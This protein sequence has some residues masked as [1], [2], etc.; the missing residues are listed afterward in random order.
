LFAIALDV[1]DPM[2]LDTQRLS[3]E[4]LNEHGLLLQAKKLRW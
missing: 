4:T 3:Y 2:I 1:D